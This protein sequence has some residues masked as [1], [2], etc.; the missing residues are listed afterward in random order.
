LKY[1]SPR[2]EQQAEHLVS[3]GLAIPDRAVAA[4][5]L[6]HLNYYRLRA[7][8]LPFERDPKQHLPRPP[9]D[10]TSRSELD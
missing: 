3:R 1:K 8:W 4:Y 7:Y 9:F 5:Y 2:F 6:A 10:A